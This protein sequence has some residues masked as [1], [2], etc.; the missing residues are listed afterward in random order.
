MRIIVAGA[1]AAG[2]FAAISA[3]AHH[4]A[5]E[6]ILLEKT[7]KILAKVRI[8]GGG[9]CN[10][11]HYQHHIRKLAANYPR[12][13]RFLRKAF[14]HFSVKDTI[15]WFAQRGVQLKAEEDGRMFPVSDSS[16]TII[17]CLLNEAER[18][19]VRIMRQS[20]VLAVERLSSGA[21]QLRME[22]GGTL[23]ADR[24]VITTGGHPKEESYAWLKAL[25]HTIVQPVPSLFT[26]NMPQEPVRQ[27]MGVVADPVRAR[28]IGTELETEGPLLV[29]HWGMSGPAVL[30]LSAWGARQIQALGYR[31]TLQV[32]WLGGTGEEEVRAALAAENLQRKQA[33]N[34]NPFS[35]PHRLWE[36]LLAKAEVPA[37]KPWVEVGKKDRNRLV[38][39]LTN[40]RYAVAGKTTFKEE[41]VTAGGVAL[42]EVDPQTM[43]SRMVPGLYFAGEV[44]DIDGITGGFNF[45]AAWTTGFLAGKLAAG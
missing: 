5:D 9:R 12:G 43:Q 35:I 40:D 33:R 45:Q 29:T 13:E 18:C 17:D 16:E 42:E 11:T 32:H 39:L 26:F 44:L 37:E 19:G 20:G 1:G 31:F 34:A 22:R 6:V 2:F 4:P 27:L 21:F 30:K 8:S 15:T 28:I 7:E 38:N 3:K 36:F 10:V 23:E 41:F 25:G 24:V 14:E